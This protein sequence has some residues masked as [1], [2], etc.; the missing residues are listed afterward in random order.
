MH[1]QTCAGTPPYSRPF[2]SAS[3]L[4]A[5]LPLENAIK[6]HA[7]SALFSVNRAHSNQPQQHTDRYS[8]EQAKSFRVSQKLLPDEK[9]SRYN[10]L[11]AVVATVDVSFEPRAH[12]ASIVAV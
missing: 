5:G 2:L 3:A 7:F 10:T 1:A 8:I 9:L 6:T 4:S 11:L 12:V